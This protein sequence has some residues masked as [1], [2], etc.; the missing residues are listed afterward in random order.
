M[1]ARF[2]SE[3]GRARRALREGAWSGQPRARTEYLPTGSDAPSPEAGVQPTAEIVKKS[4]RVGGVTA[5]R[6]RT[7]GYPNRTP[8]GG[9]RSDRVTAGRP[10]RPPVEQEKGAE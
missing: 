3:A 10:A 7:N 4:W 8:G 5:T 2:G 9:Q 1:L 6:G